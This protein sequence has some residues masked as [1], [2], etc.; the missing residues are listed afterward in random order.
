MGKLFSAN[1]AL[2]LAVALGLCLGVSYLR[3][4]LMP[5]FPGHETLVRHI[6][7]LFLVMLL[8]ICVVVPLLRHFG[9]HKSRVV[10]PDQ[11]HGDE[12]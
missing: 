7:G 10:G 12:T 6:G 3:D 8:G 1:V 11:K 2:L 9:V 4:L 5:A